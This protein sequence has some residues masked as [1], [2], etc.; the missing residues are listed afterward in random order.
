M[1]AAFGL[2]ELLG[3]VLD[4]TANIIAR[5]SY[6]NTALHDASINGQSDA[7]RLLLNR[8][9]EVNVK[10]LTATHRCILRSHFLTRSYRRCS[11]KERNRMITAKIAGIRYTRQPTTVILPSCGSFCIM[12]LA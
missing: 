9:A 1:V 8:G 2:V 6:G 4:L 3:L 7:L 11:S 10:T 12:G 5:D